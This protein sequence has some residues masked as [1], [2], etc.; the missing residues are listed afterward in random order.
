M[1]KQLENT[2]MQE[3]FVLDHYFDETTMSLHLK[4]NRPILRKKG[5]PGERKPVVDPN[6]IMTK[7][8]LLALIDELFREVESR[9]DAF[10]EINRDKSKVM[11][12]GPYRVVIVYTP[13]SDGLE[14]TVVRPV[15][16]MS[17]EEYNLDPELFDLLRN[18]A[19]GILISGA[20][21]SGKST[22]AG[23]L[24]EVYHKDQH[25]IKTIES[26]RD[27]MLN[28]DIVQYSF[29]YGSH[30]E[31]RDIL[32]LSRPDYTIYDE[33]RN[34]SDFELYKDLRL[35]GIGLVG[36]IH[37]TKPI[38]SIQRFI[39]SIE[40]GIIPQVIDTVLFIDKGG[41]AEVLQLELTAKVP[42]GMM[43]EELARP[44]I[45]VSS[46]L[47]KRPLYE[48]YTFG[49]QVMVMPIAT[50]AA[51][52][53][54]TPSKSQVVSEYAKEGIQRKL[55]QTLPCDFHLQIKGS[56]L[57]LYIPEYYKGKI[58]GKGGATINELEKQIWLRIHV[59]T[60]AEL[61]LLDVKVD[62]AGGNGK[63]EPLVIALP[64]D[65]V[66]TTMTLLID[67][68]LVYA[69]TNAQAHIIINNKETI[70]LIKRKGFL[71]VDA[72]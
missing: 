35:T 5:K 12:I 19:Q 4:A 9:E 61:P 52:N 14:M 39:G 24:I 30:D 51:G 18:K 29:T 59:K 54:K 65:Y 70:R 44:V 21:G 16:K 34:K 3:P 26:P 64:E 72:R 25:I 56:E 47:Q 10:L 60:F 53:S 11:Q 57:E 40:M 62:L 17:I 69:K 2:Q 36:V 67:D 45:V 28:D 22:F 7:E 42:D 48:I 46:F 58:I 38:D 33:V 55:S 49:E 31:V 68:G 32:L 13:L 6:E 8:A 1:S 50:D 23:A 63:N 66:N 37:A 15:K 71:L 41:V 43:S 27:L 20:P